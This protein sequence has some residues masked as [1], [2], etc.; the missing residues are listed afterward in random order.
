M[1]EAE[2]SFSFMVLFMV[3]LMGIVLCSKHRR[4][5]ANRSGL[6]NLC[7]IPGLLVDEVVPVIIVRL[8]AA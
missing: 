1:M 7:L 2:R 3:L 6:L 5:P 8:C 4:S